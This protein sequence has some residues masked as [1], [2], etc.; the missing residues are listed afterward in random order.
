VSK[1]NVSEPLDIDDSELTELVTR[2]T[3]VDG[4][5]LDPGPAVRRFAER[6]SAEGLVDVVYATVSSPLGDLLVAATPRG[7]VRLAYLEDGD[8][9]SILADL[10]RR[11]SPRVL[12]A[13][14]RLDHERRQLEDYFGGRRYGFDVAVDLSLAGP[15]AARVLDRT[16]TIP[17]GGVS[18]YGEVAA[19]IGHQRAA[20]AVGNALGSNPIPIVVPCHRVVRSGG[21]MGG[22]TGGLHRKEHLL[23][24]E[25]GTLV[26]E[27][28]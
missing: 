12:D 27:A 19:D 26:R 23:A 9:D 16:A 21:G 25:R 8:R 28:W 17:Y 6:A 13:P 2:A 24:L 14:A 22:Y 15:F 10:A 18:T 3:R 5:D 7:I 20:R 4:G 11:V 1:P